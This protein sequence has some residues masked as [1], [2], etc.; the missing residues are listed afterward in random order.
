MFF[1]GTGSRPAHR[2]GS[3][4][5][6]RG[7]KSRVE[8]SAQEELAKAREE[9]ER[10]KR[11]KLEQKSAVVIQAAWRGWFSRES[12]KASTRKA[13]DERYGA[14][15]QLLEAGDCLS[16]GAG[17]ALGTLLFFYDPGQDCHRLA[18]VARAVALA[19]KTD[20]WSQ[21]VTA[22]NVADSRAA[23]M[24][25]L[26]ELARQCLL[27]L[28]RH[29]RS[30][31][32][33]LAAARLVAPLDAA[34]GGV[35]GAMQEC[36]LLL[37]SP[38]VYAGVLGKPQA[39]TLSGAVLGHLAEA[40]M[41]RH[42]FLLLVAAL[43][44]QPH[45]PPAA[46]GIAAALGGA[47][48]GRHGHHHSHD[49]HS[50]SPHHIQ[51]LGHGRGHAH[52]HAPLP[53][54]VLGLSHQAPPALHTVAPKPYVEALVTQLTVR[55]L[56]LKSWVAAAP[57]QSLHNLLFVP[58]LWARCGSLQ[59]V[60][61]RVARTALSWLAA[62]GPRRLAAF[63]PPDGPGGLPGG[64]G[65][66]VAVLIANVLAVGPRL[67]QQDKVAA[68][69]AVPGSL[70]APALATARVLHALVSLLPLA[71][72]FGEGAAAGGAADDDEDEVDEAACGSLGL[73]RLTLS[74]SAAGALPRSVVD[75]VQGL[76][77]ISGRQLLKQMVTLL[78]P[79]AAPGAGGGGGA[80]GAGQGSANTS[81]SG[82]ATGG[83]ASLGTSPSG[84]Y[85][86]TL[87]GSPPMRAGSLTNTG[88]LG[89]ASLGAAAAA[90]AA[91]ATG[92]GIAGVQLPGAVSA[93]LALTP[94]STSSLLEAA[95][96]A[97]AVAE[98]VHQLCQLP[99]QRQRVMLGLA[100]GCDFV[101]RMWW[102]FL[103]PARLAD[104]VGIT[105][106]PDPSAPASGPGGA[107]SSVPGLSPCGTKASVS[108]SSSFNCSGAA[109]MEVEL[110]G[111]GQLSRQGS[112]NNTGTG[113]DDGAGADG[114][115][116]S[117]G[118]G[119]GGG[120]SGWRPRMAEELG[121]LLP[122]A[123]A[124]G[125]FTV[126]VTTTTLD[127]FYGNGSPGSQRPL[128]LQQL[129]DSAAPEAGFLAMLRDSLWHVLWSD[130]ETEHSTAGEALHAVLARAGGQ[131]FG[132]LYERNCR[133]AFCPTEAFHATAL[134]PDR[135][136]TEAS[137]S[138]SSAG[139]EDGTSRVW[140]VLAAAP[141]LVPFADRARLFQVMVGKER[142]EY[143][144][145]EDSRFLEMGMLEAGL[146]N[147]FVP[148]RRDQLLFD[149]FDRLNSL[150]ERLRGRVRIMFID[151]HG[152][153]EAGVDGGGLF[154]DFMEELMRAGLSAEYGL[155]A[156]NAAHQLYP[157]PAAMCVVEDAP[158]LL[159]F[160][161]RMLGK[162]MYENVLLELPLAGFFLKKFRGAHCDL[163]D[164]PTLDPELYRNLLRLREHLLSASAS[165]SAA[166]GGGDGGADSAAMDLGLTFVVADEAAAALGD[167]HAEVELKP[168]GRHIAVTADNV[169]EYIHRV[170][171]YKLN[172]APRPAVSSFLSGFYELIP[173]TWVSMF[174]GE[175]LQTLISG[176]D[177]ALD[178]ANLQQHVEYAGGYH[179]DHPV[180]HCLWE[181]LASFTPEEQGKFLKFVTSCSRAPLLG[182]RYL[183]PRLC[184]QM[185]GG[186]LDAAATQRLPTASTCM[187]LLKLPPYR[188][189]A[190]M[191]EKLL[192]AVT[193]GAGFD[194]S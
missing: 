168:G 4:F 110:A 22:Y 6:G 109:P 193:S 154:K 13:W 74:L 1:P 101:E 80:G 105:W 155:F 37:V 130:F 178:L 35:A 11:Q 194:L 43:M 31:A 85:F 21:F 111:G 60:A 188:T 165:A 106:L 132:I 41:C 73:M 173:R 91:A 55:L 99:G 82:Y 133:Q 46:S 166:G 144:A 115:G 29:R 149:G 62:A 192:Y 116:A 15:G 67:L 34:G 124:C 122:L 128:A 89:K 57:E 174:S 86:M 24:Y 150:G 164:L 190:Q 72:F 113:F 39:T 47:H 49:H 137:S 5:G 162:A 151:A 75:G 153:P 120:G 114:T 131:L 134:A 93:A 66:A 71:P 184:V 126:H 167:P 76:T 171:H 183:E 69:T 12:T 78:L 44:P 169:R 27:T 52:G 186:M 146:G 103:R 157:N 181:A 53:A 102:S 36:V 138:R 50:H 40:G 108:T 51:P 161:G 87:G 125:V 117:G 104:I 68:A 176:A 10:R 135:F 187:N 33:V 107:G 170:A 54:P 159:A 98:L 156:S 63:L 20:E 79:V 23:L 121:W 140:Q 148:I 94:P 136:L 28:S 32:P 112:R 18:S 163:N 175:E 42:L 152:Q 19:T 48:A 118:G 61:P 177:S 172:V 127:E 30:L 97:H 96:A 129:Y 38:D 58:D 77:G 142:E 88:S 81:A 16:L 185:S 123:V 158:R 59:P 100:V 70:R 141:Y 83:A 139:R 45:Q 90:A 3:T 191:R 64:G 7:G 8:L 160:L 95:E 2:G 189:V 25:R 26:K 17:G 65:A 180:I 84:G 56:A 92:A 179:Q 9:R 14:E 143:R 145:Q 147:R 119:G 182:F